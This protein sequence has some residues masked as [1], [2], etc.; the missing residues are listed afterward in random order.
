MVNWSSLIRSCALAVAGLFLFSLLATG[1]AY[2]IIDSSGSASAYSNYDNMCFDFRATAGYVTD[3]AGC[4]YSVG[5]AYPQNR[6]GAT[7][8]WTGTA[9]SSA[10]LSTSVDSRLAGINFVNAGSSA[11]FEVNLPAPGTYYV[12]VAMGSATSA[13]GNQFV[14]I[15][16][17]GAYSMSSS[18]GSTAGSFYDLT[19]HEYTASNFFTNEA[20]VPLRFSSTTFKL[21]IGGNGMA[22]TLANLTIARDLN[23]GM[24]SANYSLIES[25]LGGGGLL[26]S[27]S[28]NYQSALS[29]G[30]GAIG[31]SSSGNFQIN[32]GSQTTQDP[33]LAVSINNTNAAF[34]LFGPA[35]TATATSS[36][37]VIDY[38]SYGYAV[39][40]GGNPPSYQG[41]TLPGM[42][43]TAAPTPG[44][45]Q[46]GI[47]L[48]ANTSPTNFGANPA[49]G[50]NGVGSASANYGTPNKFRYVSGETIATA[51]KSSG[52][53]TYTISYI[54]DVSSLTPG[55]QYTGGQYIICTATY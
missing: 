16:D 44:T 49:Y 35:T 6:G 46:F 38:T 28:A 23:S 17:N 42:A 15:N 55:G 34:G 11:T 33:R 41:H 37:S 50:P 32:A 52:E 40:I 5:D 47:N 27:S 25:D 13:E 26:N 45:E 53:T 20:L 9:P 21:T 3:P 22:N 39:Q 19:G 8:G 10:N 18:S 24:D 31:N 1:A 43:T 29:T 4:T 36:F 54:A 30:D 7:F 14:S 2:I 51:P 12:G 48:V